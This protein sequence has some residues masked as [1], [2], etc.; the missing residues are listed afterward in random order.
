MAQKYFDPKDR[1][2]EYM[3]D[4]GLKLLVYCDKSMTGA[5]F[6]LNFFSGSF[7]D[8]KSGT[9]HFLEHLTI[10]PRIPEA[11]EKE[12]FVFNLGAEYGP[13]RSTSYDDTC[14][15]ATV[16]V[17]HLAK[18]VQYIFDV[19]FNLPDK[20]QDVEKQRA[21]ILRELYEE[22]DDLASDRKV[23]D[24]QWKQIFRGTPFEP[25]YAVI[26]TQKTIKSITTEDLVSFKR[27]HYIPAN[28][29]L[30]VATSESPDSIFRKLNACDIN[31]TTVSRKTRTLP[32]LFV[33]NTRDVVVRERHTTECVREVSGNCMI[34]LNSLTPN[35][36]EN[37]WIEML[38]NHKANELIREHQQLVY[39]VLVSRDIITFHD[40]F[41]AKILVAGGKKAKHSQALLEGLTELHAADKKSF[42]ILKQCEINGLLLKQWTPSEAVDYLIN[43]HDPDLSYQKTVAEQYRLDSRITFKR[44]QELW[45][46]FFTTR[47]HFYLLQYK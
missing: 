32:K 5:H 47:L 29:I 23:D 45:H 11:K 4:N 39:S 9:A 15:S 42:N 12:H 44:V 37:S 6:C 18:A 16:P 20:L 38:F 34:T 10:H 7:E 25:F 36:Y 43:L 40:L 14:Y 21:I 35:R 27:A 26:G 2:H 13:D 41:T 1:T 30:V 22:C 46:D 33:P 19:T 3:L 17:K 28:A 8:S 24:A 31:K